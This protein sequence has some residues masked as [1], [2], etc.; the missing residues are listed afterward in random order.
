[1]TQKR[2]TTKQNTKTHNNTTK[3]TCS[4]GRKP[5]LYKVQLRTQL[6]IKRLADTNGQLEI[7]GTSAGFHKNYHPRFIKPFRFVMGKIIVYI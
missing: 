5:I 7:K 3:L 6:E 2:S 1:M 4:Y